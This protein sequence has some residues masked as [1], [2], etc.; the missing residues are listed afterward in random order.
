[1][2]IDIEGLRWFMCRYLRLLEATD[3]LLSG[4]VGGQFSVG[5]EVNRVKSVISQ[6]G[7][8]IGR[9]VTEIYTVE[10]EG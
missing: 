8:L 5:D 7:E 1:M 4:V 2:K 3:K 10:N 9:G 6:C